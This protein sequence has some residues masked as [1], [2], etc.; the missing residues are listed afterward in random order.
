M[1]SSSRYFK[2]YLKAR[3]SVCAACLC[4]GG[5]CVCVMCVCACIC[6]LYMCLCKYVCIVYERERGPGYHMC[7]LHLIYFYAP[8]SYSLDFPGGARCKEVA[9]N[10]GDIRDAGLIA[11][12]GTSPGREYGNP[13]QCSHLENLMDRGA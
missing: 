8:V 1:I 4:V 12:S 9:C 13:L 11:G 10:S 7:L 2:L 6:V 3:R 5:V